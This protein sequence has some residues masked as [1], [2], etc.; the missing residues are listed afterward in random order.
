M[1]CDG[2]IKK[3]LFYFEIMIIIYSPISQQKGHNFEY[4]QEGIHFVSLIIIVHPRSYRSKICSMTMKPIK[5][6]D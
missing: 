4:L 3:I 1:I 2:F 6:G 5:K